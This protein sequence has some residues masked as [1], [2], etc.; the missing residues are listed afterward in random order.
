MISWLSQ[1]SGA[2]RNIITLSVRTVMGVSFSQLLA[3][4]VFG[5]TSERIKIANV[6]PAAIRASQLI[7]ESPKITSEADPKSTDAWEPTPIAPTVCAIVFKV[8]IAASG[9]SISSLNRTRSFAIGVSS[10]S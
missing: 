9:R 10:C 3:P 8:R 6:M 7:R 4:I 5:I 2:S 1:I